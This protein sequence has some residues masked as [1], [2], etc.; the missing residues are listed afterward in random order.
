MKNNIY[1]KY[2]IYLY[3]RITTS[4]YQKGPRHMCMTIEL[5]LLSQLRSALQELSASHFCLKPSPQMLISMG[6]PG[7]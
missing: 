6:I 5:I 3:I 2:C 4:P 7:S 1:N